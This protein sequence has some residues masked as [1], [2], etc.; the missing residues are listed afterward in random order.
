[1]GVYEVGIWV[2]RGVGEGFLGFV[3]GA[4]CVRRGFMIGWDVVFG[5]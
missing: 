1:M 3:V 4:M 5:F 2:V